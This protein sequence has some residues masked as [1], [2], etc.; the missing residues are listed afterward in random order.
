MI[1]PDTCPDCDEVPCICPDDGSDW[2]D[3]D[4]EEDD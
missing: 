1:D 4:S 2:Y 3:G